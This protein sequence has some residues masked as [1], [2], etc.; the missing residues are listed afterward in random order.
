MDAW[1]KPGRTE[2]SLEF[3][4]LRTIS[5]MAPCRKQA[6]VCSVVPGFVFLLFSGVRAS[7][8]SSAR[9][10]KEG[11]LK[12]GK[13]EG[14]GPPHPVRLRTGPLMRQRVWFGR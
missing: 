11:Q 1:E 8:V 9:E 4:E 12:D 3:H 7:C 5:L 13:N 10:R 2:T 14:G 6:S